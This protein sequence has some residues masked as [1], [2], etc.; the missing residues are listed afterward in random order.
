MS[1]IFFTL[2]IL[3]AIGVGAKPHLKDE[4]RGPLPPF[5][6]QCERNLVGLDEK[7]MQKLRNR[8][9]FAT[10]NP[11]PLLSWSIM[12][13]KREQSQSGFKVIVSTDPQFSSII[14]EGR[15]EDGEEDKQEIEY[16]GPPLVGGTVYLWKVTWWDSDGASATSEEVGHFMAVTLTPEDWN[17]AKWIAPPPNMA[18]APTYVKQVVTNKTAIGT[19]T[20][21]VSGLGFFRAYVNNV[22][23]NRRAD[24]PIALNP[25]WTNYEVRAAYMA[26][27]VADLMN[28]STNEIRISLGEGWRNTSQFP[29][30][31]TFPPTDKSPYV[32]RLILT[33]VF[34]DTSSTKMALYSDS[35]WDIQ[36]S[37]IQANSIYN[38]EVYDATMTPSV[39]GKAVETTGPSGIMYLP[40]MPYISENEVDQ[41]VAITVDPQSTDDHNR[42]VVDFGLNAAGVVRI[43]VAEIPSGQALSMNHSE[44][45]THP[46]YG[47]KDGSLYYANLRDA[48]PID[49][50]VSNGKDKVYQ[51]VFTYHGFRY[52]LVCNYPR[53]LTKADLTKVHIHTNLK[54]N[55]NFSTSSD[56]LNNI[57]LNVVRGQLSNLMS[58]PTDCDQ[59][60]ERLGWMGDAGLS[61][62]GMALNFH[63]ESFFPHR[64][65]LTK[66]EQVKGA[67]P[68]VVPFYHGGGRPSDPSWGAAYP[69]TV[70][71]LWKYYGDTNTPKTYFQGLMDYI[72]FVESQVPSSGIGKLPGR[73]GDWVPPPPSKKIDN[74]YPSAF[75]FMQNIQQVA[76]MADAL[77]DS[78]NATK[79]KSLFT[80]HAEEFN[81]AF[82]SNYQYMDD[83]QISYALP[84]V[85]GIVPEADKEK[86]ATNFIHKITGPDKS[87]VTSGIVGVKALLLALTGLKQHDIAMSI[88]NQVDYPSWGYMIHNPDEPATT[89]WELW[90]ANTAGPGMNSRNHH[91]FSSI[92]SW[93]QTDMIGLQQRE[94]SIGFKGLELHP[95]QCLDLSSARIELEHPKPI[96]Y[97]W[98]RR[99][100][101]QCGKAPQDKSLRNDGR[102]RI[103]CGEGFISK[104]LF[105]SFGNPEGTCGHHRTG[106]CHYPQ[107]LKVVEQHCLNKTECEIPT[108]TEHWS[109]SQD[110]CPEIEL[111]WLTVAVLCSTGETGGDDLAY[112]YSSLTVNASIPI[113]STANL[114]L[115]S[116]GLSDLKVY[117]GHQLIYT[118]NRLLSIKGISSVQWNELGNGLQ[119]SLLS[120]VYQ[121]TVSGS[122]PQETKRIISRSNAVLSCSGGRSITNIDWVSYGNPIL[123]SDGD[124][125]QLGSCHSGASRY[126]VERGCLGKQVCH[127]QSLEELFDSLPCDPQALA[128]GAKLAVQYSCNN[129]T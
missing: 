27:D 6:L 22:D 118:N 100:G 122:P 46:P 65:M 57:Q 111:K 124:R 44:I 35:S 1:S 94:G 86:V 20:L 85:L 72:N 26:F 15:P 97:S 93:L 119:V 10:E 69:Q 73:Y 7:D 17:S 101:L 96:K 115:P 88:V 5:N 47:P 40:A 103:S 25:G 91:M 51:P 9:H 50:Y 113:G 61:A 128:E 123:N 24:P 64:T 81:K 76:E 75:S 66:D 37:H 31:D 104:V 42:Q 54:S 126:V 60:N 83:M 19:A 14:W 106:S 129:H 21:Y 127:L 116:Y 68:D 8:H 92:S 87:H 16:N 105:A 79:L 45:L 38:G 29:P 102:L 117:D 55:S 4:K 80:K 43:N 90:N 12:H 3:F 108:S 107:S 23:L 49:Y 67:V 120:G 125:L 28:E 98:H 18:T 71:V 82:Y 39:V 110:L 30:H 59:R 11:N 34:K 58:V 89:I 99:G 48:H 121:L 36:T 112:R 53:K 33:I 78:T 77:G 13:T 52:A 62:D 63:M 84:F 95:A 2:I 74:S 56:L 41:P 109:P 114:H 32:L 70:W